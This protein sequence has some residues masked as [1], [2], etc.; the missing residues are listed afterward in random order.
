LSFY[1]QYY[2]PA[3]IAITNTN[4]SAYE[5]DLYLD[6]IAGNYYIGLTNGEL[7]Q[8]NT[9]SAVINGIIDKELDDSIKGTIFPIWAEESGALTTNAFEWAYGNGD[10]SQASFGIVVP[11]DCELFAV[12]LTLL[13]GTGE[14]EVYQNGVSTGA[15]TGTGGIGATL[16]EL[17]NPVQFLAGDNLNFRTLG[18][19]GATSGGKVVAWLRI[20]SKIPTFD[21]IQGTITPIASQGNDDDEYLDITNGNL[22]LKEAGVWVFKFNIKG[23]SGSVT[24][25]PLIQV[26]NLTTTNINGVAPAGI[27]FSWFD[28]NPINIQTNNAAAFIVAN[29]G[30]IVVNP[31]L[32]KVTA[33]Q[34]QVNT[35]GE[36]VNASLR[37][38]INTMIQNGVGANAY[39]RR[40]SGHDESTASLVKIFN[41]AS[42]EK[43]GITNIALGVAGNV[44]CPANSLVFLIEEL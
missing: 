14:V 37:F 18:T 36:R 28:T 27:D 33:F 21:R 19:A 34:Y 23:P 31:G 26:T 20:K 35:T 30:V 42:G 22:Y 15:T 12:G 2:T 9:D 41:V 8:I 29:D 13:N 25:K 38:R 3:Q 44:T 24:S 7:S 1:S 40:L 6:T 32:Y 39:Q 5:G 17:I 4:K 43:I 16:N 10:E 11:V